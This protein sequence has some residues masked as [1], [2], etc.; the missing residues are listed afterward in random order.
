M[1]MLD[2]LDPLR[3]ILEY[4]HIVSIIFFKLFQTLNFSGSLRLLLFA[5]ESESTLV[6][7]PFQGDQGADFGLFN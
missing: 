3:H 4:F 5:L 7:R 2:N 1:F 6:L